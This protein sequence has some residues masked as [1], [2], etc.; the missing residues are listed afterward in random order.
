MKKWK[1]A[2]TL[3]WQI[4]QKRF[5][6]TCS[7]LLASKYA[8]AWPLRRLLTAGSIHVSTIIC[9]ISHIVPV[10]TARG[11]YNMCKGMSKNAVLGANIGMVIQKNSCK[12]D[13]GQVQPLWRRRCCCISWPSMVHFQITAKLALQSGK[14]F[15]IATIRIPQ[16]SAV[17]RNY[18]NFF[19]NISV[20]GMHMTELKINQISFH[21]ERDN[22]EIKKF[23]TLLERN[24]L[25]QNFML[26]NIIFLRSIFKKE[27]CCKKRNE[28]QQI[29]KG[30]SQRCLQI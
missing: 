12:S 21:I 23:Y 11:A 14:Q 2:N 25:L 10:N 8:G 7:C 17:N 19:H 20:G 22:Y 3:I 13:G 28:K 6:I 9:S 26:L 5:S 18:C 16:W 24:F 4:L 30:L 15:F 29:E 27:F 1:F